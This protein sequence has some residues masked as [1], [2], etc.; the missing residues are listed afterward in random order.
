[1]G[2]AML[3]CAAVDRLELLN[4]QHVNSSTLPKIHQ[5][6]SLIARKNRLIVKIIIV[7]L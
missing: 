7:K 2:A 4:L 1:M 6:G 3:N 5:S